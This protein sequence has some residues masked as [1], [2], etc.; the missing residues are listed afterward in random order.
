MQTFSLSKTCSSLKSCFHKSNHV[1][2]DL[3]RPGTVLRKVNK[4]DCLTG[5]YKVLQPG[6]SA[7]LTPRSA[8]YT[9][10]G[11]NNGGTSSE[12]IATRNKGKTKERISICIYLRNLPCYSSH[13]LFCKIVFC[14]KKPS[15][16]EVCGGKMNYRTEY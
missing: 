9:Y 10:M 3:R 12:K 14:Y 16:L 6:R 8:K 1:P 2:G 11:N 5:R 13:I 4:L 7:F 15:E